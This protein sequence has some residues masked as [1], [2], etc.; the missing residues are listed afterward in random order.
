MNLKD[1]N[2]GGYGKVWKEEREGRN[3]V[4]LLFYFILSFE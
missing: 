1:S 4:I 3:D 2:E